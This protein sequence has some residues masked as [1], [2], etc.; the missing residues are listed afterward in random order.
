MLKAL[1]VDEAQFDVA[2][3]PAALIERAVTNGF[4]PALARVTRASDRSNYA[5]AIQGA[6]LTSRLLTADML[7]AV[8]AILQQT[9]S[10]GCRVVLL[11]GCSA[12]ACYYREP[13][14]RPMGDVDLFVASGDWREV[15]SLVRSAGFEDT[16]ATHPR[17][18]YEQHHHRI[19]LWHPQRHLWIEIHTRLYPPSSPLAGEQ[20]FH[21]D[22]VVP[23]IRSIEIDGSVADVLSDEWQL[24]YTATR[25]AA[26]PSLQRGAFPV[27]D[28]ALLIK[29]RAA[30]LDWSQV[31]ALVEGTWGVTALRLMLTYLDRSQLAGVPRPVL[32]QLARQDRFTN[33]AMIDLLHFLVT[34]FVMDG[35]PLGPLVTSRTWRTTWSTLVGPTTHWHKP[36][37]LLANLAFPPSERDDVSP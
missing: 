23:F 36:L 24:V 30:T 19:P 20:R 14:L 10:A 29:T 17:S 11:K 22:A 37:R 26:M 31:C 25:W 8:V 32:E 7:D 5:D 27:L 4:G 15:E 12:C 2:S 3:L 1:V 18:W 16:S 34:N 6:D 21:P 13:H 28:A 9:A 33:R 35:R